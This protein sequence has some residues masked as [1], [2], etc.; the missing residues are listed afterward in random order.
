[1]AGRI[2][3]P[4]SALNPE[5][6][7]I[8]RRLGFRAWREEDLPLA[9]AL[10]TDARVTGLFGGPYT[11][12][13][14]RARLE[15]EM[16]MQ[17]EFGMQYWPVFLIAG[18][19]H[20]GVCGLR[21]WRVEERVPELGYHLRPEFWGQGL[22]VEAGQA[23]IEFGFARLGASAIFA[24]HHPENAASRKV[25]LKLGFRYTGDAVFPETGILEPTYRLEA[26]S[27]R[28]GRGKL[29]ERI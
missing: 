27:V 1:M 20:V 23:A 7:L 14:V 18:G 17:R 11:G 29:H 3:K 21:P 13:Q 15:R 24:G 12:E 9:M 10:W 26:G 6:F 25:L 22:A 16:T 8:S 4:E 28:D 2:S 19:Q 5:Y